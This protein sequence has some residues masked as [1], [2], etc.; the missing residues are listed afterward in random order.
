MGAALKALLSS[1]NI[2]CL[3]QSNK[4]DRQ[5]R[6]CG[7]TSHSRKKD[8]FIH[9]TLLFYILIVWHFSGNRA[10][11]S[12]DSKFIYSNQSLTRDML[13]KF[14][15]MRMFLQANIISLYSWRTSFHVDKIRWVY[16]L[17]FLSLRKVS[18]T[19]SPHLLHYHH[20]FWDW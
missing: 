2:F 19:P 9:E 10:H 16:L 13:L 3:I 12:T 18:L 5:V 8:C 4:S 14:P 6:F 15:Y 11:K 17:S 1:L 7:V 20:S